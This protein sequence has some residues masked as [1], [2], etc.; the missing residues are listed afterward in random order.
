M[1]TQN[2]SAQILSAQRTCPMDAVTQ[3]QAI[4]QDAAGVFHIYGFE[5]S[6][7]ILRSDAVK[8]AG[9]MAETVEQA[10]TAL[11]HPPVLFLEGEE[12]HAHRT[13]TARFFTPAT[14]QN[15][16]RNLMENYANQLIA[17]LKEKTVADLGELS[18][19]LATEVAADV[20]GLTN[21]SRRGMTGRLENFLTGTGP[22]TFL[23]QLKNHW[24][25]FLFYWQD[26]RPA[27]VERQKDNNFEDVISHLLSKKYSNTEILS[28]CL[29]YAV[30]G[31]VTTRE[32]ICVAAWHFLENPA[33]KAQYTNAAETERLEILGELLR[34]EPVVGNLFRR[35]TE[36]L[37]IVAGGTTTMI[38]QGS[39][40]E[41]HVYDSNSDERTVGENA[42]VVCPQ[43][44]LPV[45][46]Q[47]PV[48]SFG[49]GHHRCPG[50]YIALH[51]S[52]IFLQKLLALPIEIAQQPTLGRNDTVKGYEI[53]NF[54]VRLQAA[55]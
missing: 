34:L 37:E 50:A 45:G 18:M 1:T 23:S 14:V 29:V 44:N 2:L 53:R 15:K 46:V 43:R 16:Y 19:R 33:L 55:Q 12:H 51:E 22:K 39:L 17:E 40:I 21:S 25:M 32:F 47:A 52:D 49:D 36:D 30:A 11:K 26:V 42:R 10:G 3:H 35:S 38:P 31:M 27:I 8:Q 54:I 20:V 5:E 48:L 7:K 6:R 9:F 24:N 28:E 13:Q 41:L 4:E